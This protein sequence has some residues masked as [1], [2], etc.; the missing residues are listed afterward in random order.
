VRP[1]VADWSSDGNTWHIDDQW[2]LG[3]DLLVAPI[4]QTNSFATFDR[5]TLA[6]VSRFQA[7]NGECRISAD[8][9]AIRID[10]DFDGEGI[11]GAKASVELQAGNCSVRFVYKADAG[12]VGLRMWTPDGREV[13][14]FHN[15]ESAPSATG[16][17]I[18]DLKAQ[19]PKSGTYVIYIGKAHASSGARHIAFR[20]LTLFQKPSHAEAEKCWSREVYLPQGDWL[21]FWTGKI[22]S[23]GRHHVV[24]A[25]PQRI[26]VFVREG[27]TLPLAEPLVTIDAKTVFNV[28]LAAYGDKPRPCRLLEDDGATFA[29]EKG[30]WATLT[31]APDGTVRRPDH[32]QPQRYRI[33]GA[34][35]DPSAVIE[36]LLG[37]AP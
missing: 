34:A 17:Q 35:Q 14:E 26:P 31:V 7:M 11:K 4:T 13:G 33:V 9:D 23:G 15:D 16:W 19:L 28:H 25:T 29:Y 8:G 32:G 3:S 1:L 6:D 2:M 27:T 20:D 5:Q 36:R 10:A 37:K 18:C 12:K 21:D 30:T 22:L 24:T